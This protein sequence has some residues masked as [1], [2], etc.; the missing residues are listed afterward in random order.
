M[1][2]LE[3]DDSRFRWSLVWFG[4]VWFSWLVVSGGGS[5]VDIREEV[6]ALAKQLG[7]N[8]NNNNANSL[9]LAAC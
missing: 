3:T 6:G 2:A 1:W 5:L 9:L 7:N 8:N 4:L